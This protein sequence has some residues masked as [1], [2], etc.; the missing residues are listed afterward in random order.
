MATH[1]PTKRRPGG[2]P[3]NLNALKHGFYSKALSKAAALELTQAEGMSPADLAPEIALLRAR[4][5][6]LLEAEPDNLDLLHHALGQ[7]ARL[8]ATHYHLSGS[9]ADRL[10]AAIHNVLESIERTLAA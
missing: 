8:C 1:Q 6:R 2:Q 4:I 10:T 5:R 9:D 3:G 7:L